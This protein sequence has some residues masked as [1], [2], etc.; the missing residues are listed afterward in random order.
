MARRLLG[1]LLLAMAAGQLSD[2][3]GFVDILVTYR[4][5]GAAI[6][7]VVAA[8]LIGGE[9]VAGVG[10][11]SGRARLRQIAAVAAVGVAVGWSVLAL[12]AFARGLAVANCGCFGVHLGQSLRWWVLLEDAELVALAA[13]VRHTTLRPRAATE[14]TAAAG[15]GGRT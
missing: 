6:A 4:V 12:Q 9:L 14:K 2:L 5:G 11:L 15:H 10:L 8:G 13:W 1:F 3:G 7:G